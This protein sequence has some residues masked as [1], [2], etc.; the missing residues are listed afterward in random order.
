[1][2][3]PGRESLQAHVATLEAEIAKLRAE[4]DELLEKERACKEAAKHK[5]AS[6]G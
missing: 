4:R 6:D 2:S 5:E 3:D 1:M